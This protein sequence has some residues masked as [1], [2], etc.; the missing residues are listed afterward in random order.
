MADNTE[1][2]LGTYQRPFLKSDMLDTTTGHILEQS[3]N[4]NDKFQEVLSQKYASHIPIFTDGS[5][6]QNGISTGAAWFC[7]ELGMAESISISPQA[8]VFTAECPAISRALD[9][10]RDH[11]STSFL[12]CTD[13]RACLSALQNPNRKHIHKYVE[14]IT[15]KITRLCKSDSIPHKPKIM[16][17]PAHKGLE[18]NEEAD[19]IA[20]DAT[21]I[22]HHPYWKLPSMDIRISLVKK[23]WDDAEAAWRRKA[24][25]G[26]SKPTGTKYFSTYFQN[27]KKP[28]FD[29][30]KLPKNIINWV[31]RARANYYNLG[32]SLHKINL[33]NSPMCQCGTNKHNLNHILWQ[34]PLLEQHR[35]QLTNDLRRKG[36]QS[37]W[38][39]ETFLSKPYVN[40]LK[41][42]SRFLQKYNISI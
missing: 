6:T 2:W 11:P 1:Y 4:I 34:C 41:I 31:C 29:D 16:W 26:H 39:I 27:K 42:I 35:R 22:L 36:W 10:T 25:T 9:I 37:P 19:K 8:S 20:K 21:T 17:V 14:D 33:A 15:H 23:M 38:S 40:E 18:G 13:S 3:A 24:D 32:E 28:W 7:P 30:I 5:R 12:I